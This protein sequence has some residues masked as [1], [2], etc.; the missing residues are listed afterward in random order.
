MAFFDLLGDAI[1][2]AQAELEKNV[3]NVLGIE[4]SGSKRASETGGQALAGKNTNKLWFIMF[5]LQLGEMVLPRDHK[6]RL[7]P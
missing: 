1:K 5:S 3:D 7:L 2:K 6:H 4:G